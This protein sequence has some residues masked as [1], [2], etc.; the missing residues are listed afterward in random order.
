M[1]SIMSRGNA[2]VQSHQWGRGLAV[3]ARGIWTALMKCV[4]LHETVSMQAYQWSRGLA[5]FASGTQFPPITSEP[6]IG[7]KEV[8]V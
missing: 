6:A 8:G 7:A 2:T 1:H 3:F 4:V 5:V